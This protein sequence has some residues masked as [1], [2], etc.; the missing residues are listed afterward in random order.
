MSFRYEIEYTLDQFCLTSGLD[1]AAVREFIDHGVLEPKNEQAQWFF[2]E[3]DLNRCMKAVR[4]QRDLD[5]NLASV[6]LALELIDRNQVLRKR[7]AYLEQIFERFQK[8]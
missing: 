8:L 3:A 4:L 7:V 1:I 2:S 6:A 5:V